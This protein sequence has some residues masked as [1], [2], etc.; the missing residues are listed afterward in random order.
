MFVS[1]CLFVTLGQKEVPWLVISWCFELWKSTPCLILGCPNCSSILTFHFIAPIFSQPGQQFIP[2]TPW[3]L[4][5]HNFKYT[6]IWH[7]MYI[8]YTTYMY[9]RICV[10]TCVVSWHVTLCFWPFNFLMYM[11]MLH[12]VLVTP[13]WFL[14][15]SISGAL[16]FISHFHQHSSGLSLYIYTTI[17]SSLLYN[18]PKKLWYA[19][20]RLWKQY[21]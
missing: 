7:G 21:W 5:Q 17:S 6:C 19:S 12:S 20:K 10:C 11:Y 1:V 3:Q 2:A 9:I 18:R 14:I 15:Y 16:P 4:Q 8:V 13:L